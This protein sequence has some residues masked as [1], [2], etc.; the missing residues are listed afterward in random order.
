MADEKTAKEV[1]GKIKQGE[2]F[3]TLAKQ[4][5]TDTGSK[6]KGEDL[7]IFGPDMMQ[8]EFEDA[9]YKLQVEEVSEPVKT[10]FDY[11]SDNREKRIKAI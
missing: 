8:K 3:V 10:A 2:D 7:G 11:H 4:Y 9:A 1:E 5:S 6:E